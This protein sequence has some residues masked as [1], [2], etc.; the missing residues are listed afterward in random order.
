M[1]RNNNAVPAQIKQHELFVGNLS[2]FFTEDD[3]YNLFSN[4]GGVY[5][6]RIKRN[7]KGTRSLQFGF[8]CMNALEEAEA[9]RRAL[10]GVMIMGRVMK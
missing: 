8:V 7:D 2:Y 5:T 3:L 1:N 10:D 9:A 6:L 4:F